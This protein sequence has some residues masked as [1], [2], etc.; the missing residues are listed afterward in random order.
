MLNDSFSLEEFGANFA[1]QNQIQEH[2]N[3]FLC[4]QTC[5][6]EAN[7][8]LNDPF[9]DHSKGCVFLPSSTRIFEPFSDSIFVV[10]L[11]LFFEIPEILSILG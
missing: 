11:D 6:P 2:N 10:F 9:C 5:N 1:C 3:N 4:P 8:R 7:H